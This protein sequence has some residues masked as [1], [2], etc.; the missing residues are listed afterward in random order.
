VCLQAKLDCVLL[1]FFIVLRF[2]G[3]AGF[4]LFSCIPVSTK[5]G[6]VQVQ[7]K[8][9][10]VYITYPLA[11]LY[12]GFALPT[13]VEEDEQFL[14]ELMRYNVSQEKGCLIRSFDNM[15]IEK[16][17]VIQGV[18]VKGESQEI[19]QLQNWICGKYNGE[20]PKLEECKDYFDGGRIIRRINIFSAK[21]ESHW[22]SLATD[23]YQFEFGVKLE[24]AQS[25]KNSFGKNRLE[26]LTADSLKKVMKENAIAF[27]SGLGNIRPVIRLL[28]CLDEINDE[29]MSLWGR[30]VS[31]S[32]AEYMEAEEPEIRTFNSI[33][34]FSLN[35]RNLKEFKNFITY[36]TRGLVDPEGGA[37]SILNSVEKLGK[38]L[39]GP[40]FL[41]DL[42]D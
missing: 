28:K 22:K 27:F 18:K 29:I 23:E 32:N 30:A 3:H 14:M 41:I 39:I 40:E 36:L 8:G 7:V 37:N 20:F 9:R 21:D 42:Q 12:K 10:M 5:S 33:D 2:T 4:I 13:D 15:E 11:Q 26:E 17:H 34:R 24:N 6:E 25:I 19:F 16:L 31:M 38:E 35:L 1:K